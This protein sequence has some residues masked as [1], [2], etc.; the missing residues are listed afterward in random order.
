MYKKE[1]EAGQSTFVL[2]V[3]VV[4]YVISVV[5][6]VTSGLLMRIH[7]KVPVLGVSLWNHTTPIFYLV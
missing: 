6:M 7:W 3:L 5:K 2:Y 4:K 1:C